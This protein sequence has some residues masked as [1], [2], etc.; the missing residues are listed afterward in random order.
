VLFTL[1]SA[2]LQPQGVAMLHEVARELQRRSKIRAVEIRG[3]A[4]ARGSTE[5]NL[6]LSEHRAQAVRDWLI[7]HGIA[8]ERLRIAAHG[9]ADLVEA[10]DDESEH[11]QNR[12]VVFRVVDSEE[13]P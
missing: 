4:D 2:E 3:Y 10:G 6:Q 1:D 9:A 5:H 13:S 7:A 11:A 12:R 8:A